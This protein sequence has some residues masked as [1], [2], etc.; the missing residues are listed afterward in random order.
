MSTAA[1]LVKRLNALKSERTQHESVWRDCFDY[2]YPLRGSG[3]NGNDLTLNSAKTKVAKLLDSV[4]TENSRTLASTIISGITPANS[5]WFELGDS[6]MLDSEKGWFSDAAKILW[7]NIHA[8]N[9]D[10]EAFEA[11]LDAVCAGWFALYIEEAKTG[12]FS[13]QQWH[14][15]QVFA[16]STRQDGVVDTVFRCYQLSAEQA[17]KEF[18]EDALSES[19]KASLRNKPDQKCDFIHAILP[20][21]NYVEGGRLAKNLPFASYHIE[22]VNKKIVRES[23]YHEFPVCVPRWMR[24]PK[25]VYGIGP[26]FD[27]LPDIK[28]LNELKRMEKAAADLAISG[29]WIAEDDGVLN[30]SSVTVGPR[31]VIVANSTDSMKPLLTGS[32]FNVAFTSEE[33]LKESIRR[34][35]MADQLP[36]VDGPVRT[37]TEFHVRLNHLRQMLGPVYGRFQ[38]E[39][40]QPLIERCFGIALRAGVFGVLPDSLQGRNISIKYISPLARSQKEV[41]VAAIERLGQNVMALAQMD[42]T[43]LDNINTDAA[44]SVMVE[45]LGVPAGVKRSEEEVEALRQQRAEAQQQAQAQAQMEQLGMEAGSEMIKAVANGG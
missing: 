35:L 12:G 15:S 45:A 20:R 21:E 32:D 38:A 22:M 7:E 26:V 17:A 40:L 14:I 42:S 44:V 31:K 29:M 33:R 6:G 30:A 34:T 28:E 1:L 5:L 9:Y 16:A 23:G 3:L 19:L 36:P 25:S 11:C 13:F 8:S 2:T 37:A 4:S 24:I 43:V 27:A 39:Y 10:A 18:G 41:D